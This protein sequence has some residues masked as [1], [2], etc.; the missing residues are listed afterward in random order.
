MEVHRHITTRNMRTMN[1]INST[2]IVLK[3][4]APIVHGDI[5]GPTISIISGHIQVP[6][7]LKRLG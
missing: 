2:W 5:Y 1:G 4:S 7:E 6:D 3:L